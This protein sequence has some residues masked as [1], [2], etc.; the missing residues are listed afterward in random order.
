V[1]LLELDPEA[2]A[3]RG[4]I[5]LTPPW[6]RRRLLLSAVAVAGAA[7]VVWAWR[8]LDMTF[9]G[10]G[11]GMS[12]VAN[13]LERMLPPAFAD[14]DR[15]IELAL[16]TFFIA[17]LGTSLAAVL[18]V[19]VAVLAARNTTLGRTARRGAR[20]LIAVCRAVPD[21]VFAAVFVR[22]LGIGVLPG[23]MAVA[24]HSV[25][26]IAKLFADAIEE[27]DEGPRDAVRSAGAGR[28]QELATAVFPQVQ[29]AWIATFLYRLDINVRS[30]VV[31]GLVGAGGIGFALQAS[32]RGLD[33][34]QALGIVVVIAGLVIGVELLST[35]L[36]RSILGEATTVGPAR[37]GAAGRFLDSVWAARSEAD[38]AHAGRIDPPQAVSD[39]PPWTAERRTRLT[40]LGLLG[41]AIAY[42]AVSVDLSPVELVTGL[43]EIART[44]GAMFP[45]SLGGLT[46]AELAEPMLVTLAVGLVATLMA[47]V[48]AI[49]IGLLAARN[50]APF[51]W[52]ATGTRVSL[53]AW[54]A[55]P[56]L[57]LAVVFVAAVGLGPVGGVL[58]L[59]IGSVPFLA[60]LVA[61]A[62]EEID[63]GP[64]EAVLA[65]GATRLQETAT[66]VLPQVVPGLVGSVLYLLDV[67]IRTSTILGI[68]GG[69][70]IGFLLFNSMRVL[71][72]DVTGAILIVI[73][74]AI[75]AVEALS[76]WLRRLLL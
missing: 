11:T 52:I 42:A 56:E 61:D 72:L 40:Y 33:Y 51:R 14:L 59:A 24:L 70:G 36:R 10:I 1:T 58:A 27:I 64:R 18:S 68:V 37:R 62:V 31:L 25:G 55:I 53:V 29:P 12:D 9:S 66:S 67:N 50:V 2:S 63:P 16:E 74:G 76:G 41:L 7:I 34:D 39:R 23:V 19:P 5:A 6:D 49:P 26:M 20:A 43:P 21:L 35:A 73:F 75:Y 32:L 38:D 46:V 60:K 45:P 47:T 3:R 15:T 4:S 57:I 22:A 44:F 48:C 65:T 17:L 13:L 28:L 30:S 71:Q 69:G 54:R 8:H